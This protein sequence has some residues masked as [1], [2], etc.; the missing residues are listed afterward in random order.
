MATKKSNE[1]VL[2][3]IEYV[4]LIGNMPVYR[5]ILHNYKKGYKP[6]KDFVK[7]VA[8]KVERRELSTKID[9]INYLTTL[10]VSEIV[11]HTYTRYKR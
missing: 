1:H 6:A 7:K 10:G 5:Y 2:N 3:A 9:I 4:Y 8:E 11:P